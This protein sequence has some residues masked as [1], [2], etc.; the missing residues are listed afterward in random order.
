MT[1]AV[2]DDDKCDV[3]TGVEEADAV[4]VAVEGVADVVVAGVVA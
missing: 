2:A 3:G 4:A 1:N